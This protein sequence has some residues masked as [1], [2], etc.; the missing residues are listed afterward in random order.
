MNHVINSLK[1]YAGCEDESVA[2]D[3]RSIFSGLMQEEI[4]DIVDEV[5]TRYT[6]EGETIIIDKIELEFGSLPLSAIKFQFPAEFRTLFENELAKKIHQSVG[7]R[8]MP[9]PEYRI[10]G[11]QYFL[12]NGVLP[13]WMDCNHVSLEQIE[14]E[15]MNNIPLLVS[16]FIENQGDVKIW[17]RAAFQLSPRLRG[18]II[19]AFGAL[20]SVKQSFPAFLD[21]LEPVFSDNVIGIKRKDDISQMLSSILLEYAP[22]FLGASVTRQNTLLKDILQQ[23]ISY[24]FD[25]ISAEQAQHILQAESV[26]SDNA[27]GDKFLLPESATEYTRG[28]GKQQAEKVAVHEAGIILLAPFFSRFF[29]NRGL[30]NDDQ[31]INREAQYKAIH[32]LKFLSTGNWQTPE[33]ELALEKICCGI[34]LDEPV[35][36]CVECDDEDKAEAESLLLSVIEHWKVLKNT[37]VNGLRSTFLQRDGILTFK[38]NNWNLRVERK[39]YDVMLDAVPWGFS[40]TVLPWNSCLIYTEW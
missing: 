40:T 1:V 19:D 9:A 6:T 14:Q 5:A 31:W 28:S 23:N 15:C 2:F 30:L 22:W 21:Q 4:N 39:A 8:R 3:L 16:F 25:N 32:L 33:Y 34:S 29:K 26:L 36:R 12:A 18:K 27:D 20:K 38:E 37:S 17:Q 11:L 7:L 13:W 24:F 35:P 10:S